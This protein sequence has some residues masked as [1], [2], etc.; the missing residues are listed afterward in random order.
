V[1]PASSRSGCAEMWSADR[2]SSATADALPS[3]KSD[4]LRLVE[5][6]GPV[7]RTAVPGS[8]PTD[9]TFG[10][11]VL[12]IHPRR[13]QVDR[14]VRQL[15]QGQSTLCDVS[16]MP[17]DCQPRLLVL[18]STTWPASCAVISPTLS[19]RGHPSCGIGPQ[20]GQRGGGSFRRW[21]S[22]LQSRQVHSPRLQPC[23]GDRISRRAGETGGVDMH[24]QGSADPDVA[25]VVNVFVLE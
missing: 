3:A 16:A 1:G 8:G 21:C 14:S 15:P 25:E 11:K 10:R 17:P 22:P 9:N 24:G 12:E 20:V 2:P 19:P 4:V 5:V 13:P 18:G 7:G 6:V 23:R